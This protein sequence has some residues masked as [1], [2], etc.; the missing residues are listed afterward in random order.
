MGVFMRAPVKRKNTTIV[1]TT[2]EGRDLSGCV[3]GG[4]KAPLTKI[5]GRYFE[6]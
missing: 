5:V 3:Y 1:S 6:K 2:S 4:V